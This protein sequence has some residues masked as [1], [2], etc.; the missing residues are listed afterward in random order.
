MPRDALAEPRA[1]DG[2]DPG[3]RASTIFVAAGS[4]KRVRLAA[5]QGV[6]WIDGLG[7]FASAVADRMADHMAE[8]DLETR[9]ALGLIQRD[10]VGAGSPNELIPAD[11]RRRRPV[12]FEPGDLARVAGLT[13]PHGLDLRWCH[14]STCPGSR[15]GCRAEHAATAR[16]PRPAHT[17]CVTSAP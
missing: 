8:L 6:L 4:G 10:E 9:R 5:E 17:P 16:R 14:R 1:V 11:Q 7:A 15:R 2:L 13:A 3:V 12:A